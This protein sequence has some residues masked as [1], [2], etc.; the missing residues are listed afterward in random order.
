[1]R[2]EGSFVAAHF[3][4][5]ELLRHLWSKHYI[6]AAGLTATDGRP[7]SVIE[8]GTLNR[9]SGPDFH[10]AVVEI[11]GV[12]YK[13]DIEFH[14][15][16]EDWEAHRHGKNPRYNKVILHV[17]LNEPV[18]PVPTRTES[19]RS[20]PVLILSGA[21]STPLEKIG[22][23]LAREEYTSRAGAIPCYR[24]NDDIPA[25]VLN[26]WLAALASERLRAKTD[27]MYRRLCEIV[28]EQ[29]LLV[30][31]PRPVYAEFPYHDAPADI[32]L[33]NST[34]PA[35]ALRRVIAWEQLLYE[36]IMDGLGY[37]KNREPFGVL[38]REL[39]ILRL[40]KIA[41]CTE[42]Q[43][44]DIQAML[45][46]FAGLLP[47]VE[48]I[49]DQ[50]SKVTA[51]QLHSSWASVRQS[52]ESAGADPLLALPPLHKAEW[53]FVPTRP[54]NF[55]TVRLAAAGVLISMLL[56][57]QFL[58]RII[59][60]VE[61]RYL[62]PGT[63]LVQIR[64]AFDLGPDLF[65][66]F[67]YVFADAAARPHALLGADRI[68]EII[69]N[70]VIPLAFLYGRVFGRMDMCEHSVNIARDVP[71][72]EDN[73]ILRKME[74]QLIRGKIHLSTSFQQ[75]GAI[76]LY[77]EYCLNVRCAECMVGREMTKAAR[78]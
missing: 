39:T 43:P 62:P 36:G 18:T 66:S 47:D 75:Q 7:L 38:A 41:A 51:H 74:K 13:G 60:I 9:D 31:E 59:A 33:P 29:E 30:A 67:H 22:D 1:M 25:S 27:R 58:K 6:N 40:K 52:L 14:R 73:A 78:S 49:D 32:P 50:Q 76:Q 69:V 23:N 35:Q 20:I 68:D 71:P 8:C 45:F 26:T 56:S 37:S 65:W 53:T 55:P 19:G 54:S 48:T 5:E 2:K 3:I 42:L 10:R 21:L 15:S 28:N 12:R 4:P 72:L 61:G 57:D 16:L 44:F 34:V 46:A 24:K 64:E 77:K 63:K 17:V 11:G 70:T